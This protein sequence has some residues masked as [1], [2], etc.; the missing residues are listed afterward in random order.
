METIY[1]SNSATIT[2]K[3][4]DTHEAKIDVN[5]DNLIWISVSELPSFKKE[6]SNLLDRYRI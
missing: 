1:D 5:G 3:I 6:L 4:V 2:A